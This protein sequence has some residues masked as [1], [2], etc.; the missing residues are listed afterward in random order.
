MLNHLHNFK[1]GSV[2]DTKNFTE[3]KLKDGEGI[4]NSWLKKT[5]QI[6]KPNSKKS[7]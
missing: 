3:E 6:H 1:E 7:L 4:K 5:P 2:K